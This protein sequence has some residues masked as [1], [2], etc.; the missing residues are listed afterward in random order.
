MFRR[1]DNFGKTLE[2]VELSSATNTF[3]V[4]TAGIWKFSFCL[5]KNGTTHWF[6]N[7]KVVEVVTNGD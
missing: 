4:P 2:T 1:T 3:T 5:S 7:A 6:T